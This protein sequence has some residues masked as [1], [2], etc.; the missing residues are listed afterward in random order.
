MPFIAS[1][2]QNGP[3]P[4][5]VSSPPDGRVHQGVRGLLGAVTVLGFALPVLAYLGFVHRYAVN[6]IWLDQWDDISLISHAY[7]HTLGLST[8]WGQHT[9]DRIFFPNLVVV[10][11]AYTTHLNV[12]VE[13]YLSALMLI[14]STALLIV[15]H[16]R[17]TPTRPWL[18]YCPVAIVML[19]FVQFRDTLWGF[20]LAWY[21]TVLALGVALCL[22]DSVSPNG[23][24]FVAAVAA[25]VVGSFSSLEGLLIWPV[26][27]VLLL[28]RGRQIA[29]VMAWILAALVS[30]GLYFYNFNFSQ[31]TASK[32]ALTHPVQAAETF[33]FNVG[34]VMEVSRTGLGSYASYLIGL[35]LFLLS[36]YVIVAYGLRR[37]RSDGS[38]IGVALVVFGL[39]FT[40][41]VTLGRSSYGQALDSRY[42]LF[43]NLI[44][45]GCYLAIFEPPTLRLRAA[46]VDK[47]RT[48]LYRDNRFARVFGLPTERSPGRRWDQNLRFVGRGVLIVAVVLLAVVGT[49]N[50]IK[51]AAAWHQKELSAVDVTV[52]MDSA[53]N[54][55]VK[56]AVFFA[57]PGRVLPQVTTPM[58]VVSFIRTED[59]VAQRHHLSL[60]DTSAVDR[61]SRVGLPRETTVV[62]IPNGSTLSGT[63]KLGAI[64]SSRTRI[65]TVHFTLTGGQLVSHIIAV[66]VPVDHGW[67]AD[68]N[69]ADVPNGQY[70]L[71]SVASGASGQV[72][73][74]KGIT[75]VINNR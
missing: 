68:W 70:V 6:M 31:S 8:L 65:T 73:N 54:S 38:P 2:P 33:F 75:V 34:N 52:N 13:E 62:A 14:A 53:P 23:W 4:V 50:G 39:L 9:Q 17:R 43:D 21:V 22:L 58:A 55:L 59:A 64:A 72:T 11:I 46:P 1:D 15:A 49:S 20:Q 29:L 41:L 26:G 40:V 3:S 12:I 35:A 45:V 61:F 71:H 69:S 37:N 10:A 24:F 67:L 57:H 44:P 56:S 30:G 18:F 32:S 60:F 27:L 19:S 42:A 28:V 36:I 25:G 5:E 47:A 48:I 74:S 7:S 63:Q 51:G 16:H 66:A